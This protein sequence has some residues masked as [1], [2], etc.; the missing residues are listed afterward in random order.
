MKIFKDMDTQEEINEEDALDYAIKKIEIT[1][2]EN[3]K[4]EE[5]EQFKKMLVEWYFSGNYVEV[6]EKKC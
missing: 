2:N 6:E 3:S 5:Q 1:I 4:N